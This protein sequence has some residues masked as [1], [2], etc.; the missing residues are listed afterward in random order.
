MVA[1]RSV[2]GLSSMDA[3]GGLQPDSL[4]TDLC[5]PEPHEVLRSDRGDFASAQKEYKSQ[6]KRSPWGSTILRLVRPT[7]LFGGICVEILDQSGLNFIN[8]ALD[9]FV[10]GGDDGRD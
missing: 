10:H 7:L 4:R 1:P 6:T 8:T 3:R 2:Y 5:D 9:V